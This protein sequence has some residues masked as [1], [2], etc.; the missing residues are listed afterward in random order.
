LYASH[1]HFVQT[2]VIPGHLSEGVGGVTEHQKGR[3]V[4]P[5]AAG[6]GETDHVL[7]HELVHAFQRDILR[8][9]NRSILS[10]PLWFVEGMA[11]YLSVGALDSNTA[12]WLRDAA[13]DRRLPSIEELDDPAWFPYRYGQALWSY[14]AGQFGEDVAARSLKSMAAGGAIG[15]IVAVTAVDVHTLSREWHQAIAETLGAVQPAPAAAARSTAVI[16]QERGG[17]LNVG[18]ALS[19]D[20]KEIVF[21][22]ERDQYSID[23]YLAD[24]SSGAIKRRLVQMAADPHL[25]AC[26]SSA[27]PA[28][29][30]RQ[31]VSSCWRPFIAGSRC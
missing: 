1:S 15:R 3:V 2:T 22:S 31:V 13:A 29:G 24:A 21:L 7:G 18:P 5:F 14:L 11:E 12:M 30:T 4:L 17:R 20:G 27:R 25:T 8:Q 23:V 16:S 9:P 19:P 6:L 10:L 26:S 28:R